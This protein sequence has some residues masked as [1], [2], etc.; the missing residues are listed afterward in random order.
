VSERGEAAREYLAGRGISKKTMTNFGIGLSP[1]YTSLPA[2]LT[3]LGYSTESQVTAGVVSLRDEDKAPY[4]AYAKRVIIPM[5]N[6]EGRVIGFT[7]R[8]LD[9]NAKAKYKNTTQ[10]PVFTKGKYL[11]GINLYRNYKQGK[12]RAMIVVEGHMDA[13]ALYQYGFENAVA[14]MGTALTAEQ[15][16]EIKRNADLVYLCFDADSAGR[17]ALNREGVDTLYATGVEIKVVEIPPEIGKDPDEFL[18]KAGKE[19]FE[20]LQISALPLIEY[21]L[22]EAKN[23]HN[24]ATGDGKAKYAREALRILTICDEVTRAA[25]LKEVSVASGISE[26]NL[27]LEKVEKTFQQRVE[28]K[29]DTELFDYGD[30]GT[31]SAARFALSCMLEGETF[32]DASDVEEKYF[33]SPQHKD[34]LKYIVECAVNAE[35]P[36]ESDIFD[37]L[38]NDPEAS[39]ILK[40]RDTVWDA[41]RAEFYRDCMSRLKKF[42]KIKEK[43]RLIAELKAET[44][45]ELRKRLSAEIIELNLRKL[46]E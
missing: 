31:L 16:T 12:K 37:R 36:K 15:C 8:S 26:D 7:G 20:K 27:K 41:T 4:D 44:N 34:V 13:V 24:L 32:V 25:Y 10:T 33:Y 29:A 43:E 30:I 18:N 3:S 23:A 1:D 9:K 42:Y 14:V 45:E 2:H 17:E 11:F 5:I 22:R 28:K 38:E 39:E 46:D 19:A 35:K 21:R 40:S 6:T